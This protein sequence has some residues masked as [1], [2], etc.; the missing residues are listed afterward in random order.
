MF[1]KVRCRENHY[2]QCAIAE[3]ISLHQIS[4][5]TIGAYS[6]IGSFIASNLGA[7]SADVSEHVAAVRRANVETKRRQCLSAFRPFVNPHDFPTICGSTV[8]QIFKGFMDRQ[9]NWRVKVR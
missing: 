3:T 9:T 2:F 8:G 4:Q 5:Q 6:T 7:D 1:A